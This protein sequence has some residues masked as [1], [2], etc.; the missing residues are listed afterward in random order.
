MTAQGG[1]PRRF[2][3]SA[4]AGLR[5]TVNASYVT[6]VGICST[7]VILLL[8]GCGDDSVAEPGR[9]VGVPPNQAGCDDTKVIR[10]PQE[11]LASGGASPTLSPPAFGPFSNTPI[12]LSGERFYET[13]D[14][15][16]ERDVLARLHDGKTSV[17]WYRDGLPDSTKNALRVVVQ[18]V[19]VDDAPGE[20]V[21]VPW[22]ASNGSFP[23]GKTLVFARWQPD[24]ASW[25]ACSEVSEEVV[26]DFTEAGLTDE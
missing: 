22:S 3:P 20:L 13:S 18:Q 25:R 10:K 6:R 4:P 8:S 16:T 5:T 17:V 19:A 23:E 7:S 2:R 12:P 1:R 26:L 9:P 24:S 14:R 15:P 21:A 11:E